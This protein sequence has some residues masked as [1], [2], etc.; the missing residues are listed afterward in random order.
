M[1]AIIDIAYY[2]RSG[3]DEFKDAS[4]YSIL[5]LEASK[6]PSNS[7]LQLIA[8]QGGVVDVGKMLSFTV[9][10]TE[11]LSTIT[12][13]VIARGSV[14]LVQNMA[15][16][17]DLATITF[18]ATSQMA[19]K[20]RLVVYTIRSS[21]QEILVDAT[22]F[23]VDGVFRNNVSL[24]A[25]R[26]MAEPGASVKYT[27]KADP[28]SYCA[29]LAVDQSV[30]LLK[31]GNDITKDLVEH[32]VEQ[33]DTTSSRYGSRLFEGPFK[34]WKRSIWYPWWGVGGR[35]AAT[36]FE[37]SGLVVL[38]DALL[39]QSLDIVE[40]RSVY[41]FQTISSLYNTILPHAIENINKAGDIS[42]MITVSLASS[43]QLPSPTRIR[44]HFSES[45]IWIS[46]FVPD[47]HKAFSRER[48]NC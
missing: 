45:W 37:N 33:Y 19:P 24:T 26:S 8:D 17:G 28:D 1:T 30:L 3:K 2:D 4:I 42:E 7:F 20:A 9:K 40:R 48:N 23:R 22:D 6:S 13:Q 14:I 39:Y 38:T 16:N 35:D 10:A 44:R 47:W 12:Y 27:I 29:L 31:S 43:A 11:P 25:D 5:Y 36:I 15:V 46:A 41:F 34:R 18:T 32:D 21:N